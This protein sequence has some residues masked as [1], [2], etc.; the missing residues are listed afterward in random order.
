MLLYG[1]NAVSEALKSGRTIDK[2]MIANGLSR[3]AGELIARLK[4]QKIRL[5]F[6]DRSVLDKLSAGNV[7]QGFITYVSDFHYAELQEAIEGSGRKL[8]VILDGIKD[9]HNFGSIVRSCECFGVS[10]IIIQKNRCVQVT[11]TVERVSEGACGYVK[12]C[13]VTNI[14]DT[15]REL[16]E[17]GVWVMA[18][19][20]GGGEISKTDLKGDIAIV[21]GGEGE[22]VSALTKKLCDGVITIPMQG[23]I[24]SLNAGVAL[25]IALYEVSR[26]NA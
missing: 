26:Q 2:V 18:A 4:E 5:Q 16:K 21:V 11:E 1:R 13:R 20:A 9:P 6:A 19:E 14:N 24:N 17:K 23:K 7:H 15:I 12:I 8:I 10:G 3:Q 25:G 22:G